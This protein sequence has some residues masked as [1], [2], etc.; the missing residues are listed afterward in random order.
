MN[1]E[2][3]CLDMKKTS[4]KMSIVKEEIFN[5]SDK[6]IVPMRYMDCVGDYFNEMIVQIYR[7]SIIVYA[8]IHSFSDDIDGIIIPRRLMKELDINY[9]DYV[10]INNTFI[11]KA[12]SVT[13]KF[14]KEIKELTDQ[15][16]MIEYALKDRTVIVKGDV[17]VIKFFK[18]NIKFIIHD[19]KPCDICSII[20]SDVSLDFIYI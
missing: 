3:V 8:S 10:L 19:V 11:Q 1:N 12:K 20:N 5:R 14:P 17:V 7:G 6:V 13:I 9:G 4:A 15:V 18:R 2:F 16:S